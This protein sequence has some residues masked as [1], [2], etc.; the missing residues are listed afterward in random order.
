MFLHLCLF[1]LYI[2]TVLHNYGYEYV[3]VRYY[4]FVP[5]LWFAL[6]GYDSSS[7]HLIPLPIIYPEMNSKLSG[8]S[9]YSHRYLVGVNHSR[10]RPVVLLEG[11]PVPSLIYSSVQWC[12]VFSLGRIFS[13]RGSLVPRLLLLI[14]KNILMY[15]LYHY[16]MLKGKKKSLPTFL[17]IEEKH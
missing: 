10:I 2:K 15:Q 11:V 13:F 14:L 9:T 8:L 6:V 4:L 12:L 16:L 3:R 17:F 7:P 5:L 1:S